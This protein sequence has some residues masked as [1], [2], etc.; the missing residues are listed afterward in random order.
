MTTRYIISLRSD[1]ASVTSPAPF[2][3][4]KAGKRFGNDEGTIHTISNAADD[5]VGKYKNSPESYADSTTYVGG[6]NMAG[7]ALAIV[8]AKPDGDELIWAYFVGAQPA[9]GKRFTNFQVYKED[10]TYD[11]GIAA[12]GNVWYKYSCT[13]D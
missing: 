13:E 8:G 6:T 2:S 5:D 10:A 7:A 9:N 3:A 11:D 4:L 12:R 1:L